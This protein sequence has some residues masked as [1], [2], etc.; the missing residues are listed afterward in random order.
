MRQVRAPANTGIL[1][2]YFVQ[3]LYPAIA[4]MHGEIVSSSTKD[5]SMDR[6][7]YDTHQSSHKTFLLGSDTPFSGSIASLTVHLSVKTMIVGQDEEEVLLNI[8]LQG[9]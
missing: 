4:M 9:V 1:K 3:M 6:L 7:W 5:C 8:M 2:L